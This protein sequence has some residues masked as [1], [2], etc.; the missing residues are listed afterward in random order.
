M[1]RYNTLSSCLSGKGFGLQD[2]IIL[3]MRVVIVVRTELRPLLI[4][5]GKQQAFAAKILTRS[6]KEE[7][8]YSRSFWTW[9]LIMVL[10]FT[11]ILWVIVIRFHFFSLY[12]THTQRRHAR[13][14]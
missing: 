4:F 10:W 9:A 11:F 14:N 7:S 12:P 2:Y 3:K 13:D 6:C 5:F 1:G 8:S